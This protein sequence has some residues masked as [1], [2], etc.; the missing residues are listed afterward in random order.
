[1][2]PFVEAMYQIGTRE[3]RFLVV[4][5]LTS[6]LLLD[7]DSLCIRVI[8]EMLCAS[9]TAGPQAGCQ[10]TVPVDRISVY[11]MLWIATLVAFLQ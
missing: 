7:M 6:Y 2:L 11:L 4:D 1:M 3:R 9:V 8:F 5:S 10:L